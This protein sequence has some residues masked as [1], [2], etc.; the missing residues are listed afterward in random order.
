MNG[1]VKVYDSSVST[2]LLSGMMDRITLFMLVVL[3][4]SF[5]ARKSAQVKKLHLM[6]FLI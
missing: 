3:D 1:I 4:Q 5:E 2:D 6:L